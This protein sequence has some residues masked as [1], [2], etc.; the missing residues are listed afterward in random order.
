MTKLR[1]GASSINFLTL[2]ETAEK[3]SRRDRRIGR[4]RPFAADAVWEPKL[5][6]KRSFRPEASMPRA[7]LRTIAV[8][9]GG[10]FF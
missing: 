9:L 4:K 1:L 6:G 7:P 10:D 3:Y 5:L 2:R 8:L